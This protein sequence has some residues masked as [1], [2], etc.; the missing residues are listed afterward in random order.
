MVTLSAVSDL[1]LFAQ[2]CLTEYLMYM[3]YFKCRIPT[4]MKRTP[5]LYKIGILE[6]QGAFLEHKVALQKAR[7]QLDEPAELALREIRKADDLSDD[8]DGLIIPGEW[9]D[10]VFDIITTLR[11]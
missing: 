10:T 9:A 7:A 11:T 3:W 5:N 2:D 6:I 4:T 8:L 1:G